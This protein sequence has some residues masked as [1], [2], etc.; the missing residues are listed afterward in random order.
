MQWFN[1]YGLDTIATCGDVNR[2]VMA[3]SHPATSPFQEEVHAFAAKIS[4]HL[5]PTT[6]AFAEIWLDGQ[7]L[8]M[9]AESE[10]PSAT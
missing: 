2:N 1:D 3:G 5:L 7:R 9:N 8:D 6:K 10:P 4:E